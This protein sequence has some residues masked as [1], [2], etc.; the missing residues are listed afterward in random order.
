LLTI[1]FLPV[2]AHLE[3]QVVVAVLGVTGVGG[4]TAAA[5]HARR[6]P[7]D[8]RQ[9][10]RPR[11]RFQRRICVRNR[12]E[13]S[14]R[15]IRSSPCPVDSPDVASEAQCSVHVY[16]SFRFVFFF[17]FFFIVRPTSWASSSCNR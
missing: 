6:V 11:S 1:F 8:S 15:I 2:G 14:V 3:A 17:F 16:K 4:D 12:P 7:D 9:Q 5:R 13:C 10:S